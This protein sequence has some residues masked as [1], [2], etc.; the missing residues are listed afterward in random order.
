MLSLMAPLFDERYRVAS[1]LLVGLYY[2]NYFL[3]R[4]TCMRSEL[5]HFIGNNRKAASLFACSSRF[6]SRV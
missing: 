1:E 2:A 4:A 5:P 3:R 6:D